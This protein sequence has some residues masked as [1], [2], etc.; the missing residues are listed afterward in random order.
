MSDTEQQRRGLIA[1]Q[2]TFASH[3]TGQEDLLTRFKTLRHYI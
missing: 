3:E 1:D 2:Q